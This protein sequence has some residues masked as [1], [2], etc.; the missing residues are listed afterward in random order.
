MK[1]KK[2]G[3]RCNQWYTAERKM[4]KRLRSTS[5]QDKQ[6]QIEKRQQRNESQTNQ[7]QW[8]ERRGEYQQAGSIKQIKRW[9]L[10]IIPKTWYCEVYI[11]IYIKRKP[12]PSASVHSIWLSE[13]QTNVQIIWT[14]WWFETSINHNNTLEGEKHSD[15]CLKSCLTF[16]KNDNCPSTVADNR[17]LLSRCCLWKNNSE[18]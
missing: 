11:Y 17:K 4:P 10:L 1:K 6:Q 13:Q 16:S 14:V 2:W 5:L 12:V 7:I 8:Q 15:S 18:L 3:S 9:L